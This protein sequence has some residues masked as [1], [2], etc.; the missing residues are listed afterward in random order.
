MFF[1]SRAL[2]LQVLRVRKK[3]AYFLGI[4]KMA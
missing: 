2:C 1:Q 4:I 3:G